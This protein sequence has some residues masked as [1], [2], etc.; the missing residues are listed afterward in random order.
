MHPNVPAED[1]A[2]VVVP[3]VSNR[4]LVDDEGSKKK[5]RN[6]SLFKKPRQFLNGLS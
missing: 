4:T 2:V 3:H 6:K 1:S 5:R